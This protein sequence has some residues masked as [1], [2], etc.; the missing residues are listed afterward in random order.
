MKRNGLGGGI[1]EFVEIGS[2]NVE[3]LLRLFALR[4]VLDESIKAYDLPGF[5]PDRDGDFPDDKRRPVQLL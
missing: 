5:V 2:L 4:D 1:E 3:L